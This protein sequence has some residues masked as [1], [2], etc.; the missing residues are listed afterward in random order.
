V[1][2]VKGARCRV[3]EEVYEQEGY[4]I[5]SECGALI[6]EADELD[7]SPNAPIDVIFRKTQVIN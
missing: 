3:C 5:C 2:K 7:L 4:P 6:P 1:A